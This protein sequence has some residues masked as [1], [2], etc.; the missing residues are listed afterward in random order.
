VVTE[1]DRSVRSIER[2]RFA[3]RHVAETL[4]RS[5][6]PVEQ[7]GAGQAEDWRYA[8]PQTV[9]RPLI[10][11]EEQ[12][13]GVGGHYRTDI[14]PQANSWNARVSL[15]PVDTGDPTR[16]TKWADFTLMHEMGHHRS[17]VENKPTS[18]L[19]QNLRS[20]EPWDTPARHGTEE[21]NADRNVLEHYKP[22]P[23]S[24]IEFDPGS[25]RDYT[26]SIYPSIGGNR[27]KQDTA[28]RAYD[29][30]LPEKGEAQAVRGQAIISKMRED[31]NM[32]VYGRPTEPQSVA[33][34]LFVRNT[35]ASMG[36]K[37]PTELERD[38]GQ[39][40]LAIEDEHGNRDTPLGT[41]RSGQGVPPVEQR[42]YD[43]TAKQQRQQRK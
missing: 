15:G 21:A 10:S 42:G 36:E 20:G 22:D 32:S 37:L 3:G 14:G 30:A 26:F 8:Q 4:A 41:I 29:R 35:S 33:R 25:M 39:F 2:Q 9:R 11:I 31:T 24:G 28:Q 12:R 5:S 16:S 27:R 7:M 6:M 23:R 40:P 43:T 17:S 38:Y 34:H 18:N 19:M 13:A 1:H